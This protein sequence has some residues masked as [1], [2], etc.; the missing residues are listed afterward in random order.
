M[1]VFF[2]NHISNLQSKWMMFD[3]YDLLLKKQT[4]RKI[5]ISAAAKK[6]VWH[7][8]VLFFANRLMQLITHTF[9]DL[10]PGR[11]G[12][13]AMQ[14]SYS[15]EAPSWAGSLGETVSLSFSSAYISLSVV[16]HPKLSKTDFTKCYYLFQGWLTLV[17]AFIKDQGWPPLS[18]HWSLQL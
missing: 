7:V 4:L 3:R 6:T 5:N 11:L 9:I 2:L 14:S 17:L 10:C 1:M 16:P 12:R 18:S 8:N 13:V 15:A